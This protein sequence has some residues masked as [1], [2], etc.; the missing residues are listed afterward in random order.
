MNQLELPYDTAATVAMP[1]DNENDISK[2]EFERLLKMEKD[3]M[4]RPEVIHTIERCITRKGFDEQ[5]RN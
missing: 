2:A 4:Q 1:I 5:R 3:E